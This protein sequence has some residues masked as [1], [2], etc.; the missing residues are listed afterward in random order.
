MIADLTPMVKKAILK[1]GAK[2]PVPENILF[3]RD[4]LSEGEID[5]VG[6]REV[7]AVQQAID[8]I[9]KEKGMDARRQAKPKVTFLIV[10]KR[11]HM[12]FFGDRK[13]VV[14]ILNYGLTNNLCS[15]QDV[16]RTGNLKAGF[17][18]TH[19]V[20]SP[21]FNDFYLQSHAA[22]KGSEW[23]PSPYGTQFR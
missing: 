14:L 8:E 13:Y 1:F 19:G 11:H 4:G 6:R 7:A 5:A 10:A 3:Y 15:S 23:S 16:D 20:N 18:T 2:N 22:I 21:L 17:V 12:L 9:W